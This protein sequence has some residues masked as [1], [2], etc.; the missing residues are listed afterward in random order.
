MANK[1]SDF[2]PQARIEEHLAAMHASHGAVHDK[3]DQMREHLAA[4]SGH[5][6][7]I[8]GAVKGSEGNA[9]SPSSP[10]ESDK[11]G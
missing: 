4:M 7:T 8:A 9:P 2:D 11:S 1:M 10:G 5:L 6:A 3:L